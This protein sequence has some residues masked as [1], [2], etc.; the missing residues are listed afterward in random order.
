MDSPV[1]EADIAAIDVD[2]IPG[3]RWDQITERAPSPLRIAGEGSPGRWRPSRRRCR[4]RPSQHARERI[5]DLL[6][7]IRVNQVALLDL[8][9]GVLQFGGK[10]VAQTASSRA[11]KR[12]PATQDFDHL[13]HPTMSLAGRG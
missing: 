3:T 13:Q 1:A 12:A 4:G 9:V 6:V 8:L 7:R 2:S 11:S 5:T 10:P